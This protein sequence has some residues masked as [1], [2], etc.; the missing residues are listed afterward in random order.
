M[1]LAGRR[2]VSGLVHRGYVDDPPVAGRPSGLEAHER[3]GHTAA[4]D[5]PVHARGRR[6]WGWPERR[7][8]GAE[9][10]GLHRCGPGDGQPV[11][12]TVPPRISEIAVA[13]GD[14]S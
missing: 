14:C 2:P 8:V 7:D 11:A 10:E 6:A 4:D 1:R 3:I 9:A 5:H 13:D 12:W